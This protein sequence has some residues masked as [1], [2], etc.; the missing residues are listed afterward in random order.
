MISSPKRRS[1]CSAPPPRA[2]ARRRRRLQTP[3]GS[4][5]VPSTPG[6]PPTFGTAPAVGPAVSPGDL[7]RG[8][9]ARA[10][11]ADRR[12][13]AQMA[14]SSWR[15]SMARC[16][17]AAPG[18][19]RCRSTPSVAPGDASGIP[20]CPNEKIGPVTRSVRAQHGR[21][22]PASGERRRHRVRAGDAALALDR[23]EETDVERLTNIYLD[24]IQR[25]DP[26]LRCIITLTR[27]HALAQ[28]KQADA[29]IA[30]G[31]Y[32]GPLHGIPW[33]VKDLLDTA[34]IR[35][36]LGRGAVSAIA[37]RRPTPRSSRDS[38]T[39]AR[40]SSRSSA[41]A[42]SRSTTSGSAGRR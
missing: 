2:A 39:P 4:S 42:R 17:S 34:G 14:A 18:R 27:D 19:G 37:C 30:A 33:G 20:H 40:S 8:G 23:D 1:D 12:A 11:H 21:S 7:R 41:S 3:S 15:T 13:S 29:E 16:S 35:D 9:E 26:K 6:A 24:R 10:G 22:R 25:L 32:R 36:D 5:G 38:T 31:K 28:A